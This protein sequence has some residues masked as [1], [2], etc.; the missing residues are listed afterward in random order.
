[1][2]STTAIVGDQYGQAGGPSPPFWVHLFKSPL[3]A[4]VTILVAAGILWLVA[5]FVR[6]GLFDATWSGT[7]QD[8]QANGGAC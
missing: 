6:W 7:S 8:C 3:N 1:M 5:G 4:V 2:S